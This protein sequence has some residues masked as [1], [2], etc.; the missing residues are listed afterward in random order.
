[1]DE[2][3]F[4]IEHIEKGG[5]EHFMLKEIYEQPTT[6]KDALRGR[7]LADIG[8]IKLGGLT[9]VEEKLRKARRIIL[10]AC[11]TSWHSAFSR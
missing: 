8:N 5:F 11:G 6:F 2:L 9:E 10:T 1:M 4:D 7:L 3:E